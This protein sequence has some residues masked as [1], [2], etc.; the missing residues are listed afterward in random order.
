MNNKHTTYLLLCSVTHLRD[1]Q[2]HSKLLTDMKET[3]H[4]TGNCWLIW[5]RSCF[6]A[7]ITSTNLRPDLV[8]WPS[9]EFT[10]E[11]AVDQ[12]RGL[13]SLWQM[14]NNLTG[15]SESIK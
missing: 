9:L 2:N 15:E 11:D 6:P 10:L 13:L 8:L 7:E 14:L 3:R 1:G 5:I 4:R 12:A